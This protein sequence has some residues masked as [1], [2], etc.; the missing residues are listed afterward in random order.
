MGRSRGAR[1]DDRRSR[2]A[3]RLLRLG[4]P[5]RH[6]GPVVSRCST[7]RCSARRSFTWGVILAAIAVLAMI[8]VL[9]TM[10]QYFQ[11]VLGTDAMGS[12][13]RLLPLIGGL[14]VGRDARRSARAAARRE[15]HRRRSGSPLLA[16]GLLLGTRPR[17]LERRLVAG[18][19]GDRRGRDG[20]RDG[21]R[22][23]GRAVGAVG[24]AQRR[25]FGGPAG[26]QQGRRPVRHGD[27]RQ[28]AQLR[29]PR[30]PAAS[31]AAARRR[32]RRPR[33]RLRRR[34]GRRSE[35]AFARA[36]A[37]G[38]RR[39]RARHGR[40]PARVGGDRRSSASCSPYSSCRAAR[41]RRG[42]CGT[43]RSTEGRRCPHHADA[44]AGRAA[45][46]QEGEDPRRDPAH[47]LRLFTEQGYDETTV[48]QIADAAE[49]SQST[50]FRYFPTKEDV[51]LHDATT[52]C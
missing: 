25:R 41:L 18:V 26:G 4:A 28:R 24:G 17:R 35:L 13:L 19:D 6:G 29:L 16:V 3:R 37:L 46:A 33:E 47:A 9:F 1:A 12:G 52:R 44:A 39:V 22:G 15:A 40:G 38:A 34:R 8:G 20:S 43:T 27:P 23:L 31:G 42:R 10:P 51:V 30:A 49:V 36:A 11:G 21:D 50:F 2:G 7:L 14:I 48:D 5:A 45:R 32:A